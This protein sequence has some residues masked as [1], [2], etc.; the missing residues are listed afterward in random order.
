[1]IF[2][3]LISL[4]LGNMIMQLVVG[5]LLEIVHGTTRIMIIYT[6]GKR[7]KKP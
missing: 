6:I 5:S 3:V 7:F 1:M 4:S 2:T